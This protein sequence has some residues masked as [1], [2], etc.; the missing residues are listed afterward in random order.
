[1]VSRSLDRNSHYP[2][3]GLNREG[4]LFGACASGLVDNL[5]NAEM[6]RASAGPTSSFR[7][8]SRDL[9]PRGVLCQLADRPQ[10]MSGGG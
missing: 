3:D 6:D 4:G 5:Q 1:M 9:V 7:S 8:G 10:H 2:L